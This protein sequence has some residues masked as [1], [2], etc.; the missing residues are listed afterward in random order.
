MLKSFQEPDLHSYLVTVCK[1]VFPYVKK[2]MGRKSDCFD[3]LCLDGYE[4]D[5]LKSA[6]RTNV[7]VYWQFGEG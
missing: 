1:C 7:L 4:R 2:S 5:L 6:T 3:A